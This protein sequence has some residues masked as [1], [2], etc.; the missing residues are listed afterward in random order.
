MSAEPSKDKIMLHVR[1]SPQMN[2]EI[3][4]ITE[5]VHWSRPKIVIFALEELIAR[6]SRRGAWVVSARNEPKEKQPPASQQA[7][8]YVAAALRGLK[9]LAPSVAGI[10]ENAYLSGYIRGA[11]DEEFQTASPEPGEPANH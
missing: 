9:D 5:S 1:I 2:D 6:V 8:D 4:A 7:K 10:A 3:N 11:S